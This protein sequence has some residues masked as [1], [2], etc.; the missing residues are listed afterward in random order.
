[1]LEGKA[2]HL[3]LDLIRVSN[4]FPRPEGEGLL[5]E[6]RVLAILLPGSISA[7]KTKGN[8]R[9]L[10]RGFH[11]AVDTLSRIE[12]QILLSKKMGF[13]ERSDLFRL[14]QRILDVRQLG[15]R[16]FQSHLSRLRKE[17]SP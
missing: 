2:I 10:M 16:W 12:L 14:E 4:R 3:A 6:I 15:R 9:A 11:P 8:T 7:G 1:M 13:L 5:Q 17:R